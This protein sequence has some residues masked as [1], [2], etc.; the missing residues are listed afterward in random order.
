[1]DKPRL[2]T[3]DKIRIGSGIFIVI[4]LADETCRGILLRNQRSK[5]AVYLPDDIEYEIIGGDEILY[6][7]DL[8]PD[9]DIQGLHMGYDEQ[10]RLRK[11][12]YIESMNIILSLLENCGKDFSRIMDGVKNIRDGIMASPDTMSKDE[13]TEYFDMEK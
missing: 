9:M 8:S 12:K 11:K 1:M 5:I 3:G 4:A 2:R 10:E 7:S 13:E 6:K